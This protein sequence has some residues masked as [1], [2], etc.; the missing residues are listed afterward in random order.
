MVSGLIAC[1]PAINQVMYVSRGRVL[2]N[3]LIAAVIACILVGLV[4]TQSSNSTNLVFWLTTSCC[5]GERI[6]YLY[7]GWGC[8]RVLI[9]NR[10]WWNV[11]VVIR[12]LTIQVCRFQP[13]VELRKV[14]SFP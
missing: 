7:Y 9:A 14:F 3:Y 10:M 13:A 6:V 4:D 11:C 1:L 2:C 5:P 8:T 12:Y